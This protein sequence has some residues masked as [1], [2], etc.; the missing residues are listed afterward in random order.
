MKKN[1]RDFL[2]YTF[3]GGI[4]GYVI[5]IALNTIVALPTRSASNDSDLSNRKHQ[6][7]RVEAAK[8][9]QEQ[10]L[11]LDLNQNERVEAIH[12]LSPKEIKY[13]LDLLRNR[14]FLRKVD[15]DLGRQLILAWTEKDSSGFLSWWKSNGYF[16]SD[17][18]V[19]ASVMPIVAEDDPLF[20]IQYSLTFPSAF[21]R[22]SAAASL[23]NYVTKETLDVAVKLSSNCG[24]RSEGELMG[25]M[26]SL[27]LTETKAIVDQIRKVRDPYFR[28]ALAQ[29]VV[30]K[31]GFLDI[32]KSMEVLGE[33]NLSSSAKDKLF[34]DLALKMNIDNANEAIIQL[35]SLAD[36]RLR[37][38]YY[39]AMFR[40]WAKED[41]N[42]ALAQAKIL[43]NSPA[44]WKAFEQVAIH[45][46]LADQDKISNILAEIPSKS[47]QEAFIRGWIS[48]IET[49]SLKETLTGP[50]SQINDSETRRAATVMLLQ[51]FVSEDPSGAISEMS[52]MIDQ[53]GDSEI[54]NLIKNNLPSQAATM[55]AALEEIPPDRRRDFARAWKAEYLDLRSESSPDKDL[56]L[57]WSK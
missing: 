23:R 2:L 51:R 14:K 48:K 27:A 43:P 29:T 39:W 16:L 42:K 3:G 20:A 55:V 22:A 37:D 50:I 34:G 56:L 1:I 26:R 7:D 21:E 19:V 52:S 45:S 40:K 15:Q 12:G 35:K 11:G 53:S 24:E 54:I 36:P 49:G 25:L 6:I 4:S 28:L 32:P 5:S 31:I 47:S 17:S 10:L 13:H 41:L 57:L 30:S 9:S 18:R 33:L 38:A 46:A 44:K 8:I